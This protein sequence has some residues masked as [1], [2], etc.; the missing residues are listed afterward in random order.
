MI[1]EEWAR[2]LDEASEK[3]IRWYPH[4]MKGST[5][6]SGARGTQVAINYNPELTVRQA[7]YPIIT[8]PREEALTPFLLPWPEARKGIHYRKIRRAW[9]NLIKKGTTEKLRSCGASPEYR[10]W[11]EKRAKELKLP[12]DKSLSQ[13]PSTQ[14]YEVQ[15]TLEVEKLKRSL[16]QTKA[17]RAHWK[18]KLEEALEEIHHEKHLNDKITKK[19]R[20]E[21]DAHLRIGSYLKVADQEMCARRVE[22]DQVTKDKEQ[23]ERALL[24]GQRR[25]AEQQ[26][27]LHQLQGKLRLLEEELTR[28]NLSK[29]L[30]KEQERKI[31]LEAVQAR[32]KAE[33][34]E[35]RLKETIQGLK[36]TAEGWKRRCKDIADSAE[37]QVNA[38]TAETASWK[39]KF[40]KLASLANQALKDIPRGLK[41]REGMVGFIK[42][43]REI[44]SFLDLCRGFYDQLKARVAAP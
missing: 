13:D 10:Q 25:E 9:N 30:L 11:V 43:P 15:E 6:S 2:K 44:T 34:E 24:D 29:E 37:E 8:P 16:D 20:T 21:H 40:F 26:E 42:M 19:A 28:A 22:R 32:S 35:A 27:Q 12:W 18:R 39:D 23:L 41:A 36:Q 7:G 5:S 31:L 4:G 17:E 3:S 38:A 14:P 33:A 1:K